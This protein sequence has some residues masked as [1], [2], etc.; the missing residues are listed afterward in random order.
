MSLIEFKD[1]K[2][3]YHVGEV[4]IH[5]LNGVS[6]NIEQGQVTIICGSSGAGKSTI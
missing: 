2:M 5:A 3:T 4:D 1:V 6:F